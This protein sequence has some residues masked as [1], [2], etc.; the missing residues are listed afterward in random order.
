MVV[1][2]FA[3]WGGEQPM[4][5]NQ[6][7]I[8]DPK[9]EDAALA[10][11]DKMQAAL[12]GAN[13]V[14]DAKEIHSLAKVA[15]D[16]AGSIPTYNKAAALI[17]AAEVAMEQMLLK[18][19]APNPGPRMKGSNKAGAVIV[20]APEEIP[21]LQ[22]ILGTRDKDAANYL[23]KAFRKMAQTVTVEQIHAAE[24]LLTK[25]NDRLTRKA[26]T[27]VALSAWTPRKKKTKQ[28]KK[29]GQQ[30]F[31]EESPEHSFAAFQKHATDDIDRALALEAK[32]Y[33]VDSILRLLRQLAGLYRAARGVKVTVNLTTKRLSERLRL[34]T[35]ETKR[36]A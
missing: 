24:K 29:D 17:F 19:R 15:K 14:S 22:E 30:R 25:Y 32:G 26:V 7:A 18:E 1:R 20:T 21:T 10:V 11:L 31:A 3:L 2:A 35:T 34:T 9:V 13:T 16:R 5:E 6:L 4:G 12:T 28:E 23:A 8:Y 33:N 36:S 27:L